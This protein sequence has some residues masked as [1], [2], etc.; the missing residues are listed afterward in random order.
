MTEEVKTI[1]IEN[2]TYDVAS[3]TEKGVQLVNNAQMIDQVI[4]RHQLDLNIANVAKDRLVA[5]LVTEAVNFKEVVAEAEP[6]AA[7]AP[8]GA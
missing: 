4:A 8:A 2:K 3:L 1:T 5:E 7:E 6:V